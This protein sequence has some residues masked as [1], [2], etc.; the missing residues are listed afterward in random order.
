MLL[1]LT[2]AGGHYSSYSR[3]SQEM[4]AAV[5]PGS[6]EDPRCADAEPQG[7]CR[8][9]KEEGECYRHQNIMTTKCRRTCNLC[10]S[11]TY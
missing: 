2:T 9:W 6:V 1:V 5:V 11:S 4:S 7:A 3:V 8:K 10:G